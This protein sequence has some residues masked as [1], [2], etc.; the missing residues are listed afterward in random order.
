MLCCLWVTFVVVVVAV[1]MALVVAL[2]PVYMALE[3]VEVVA[4]GLV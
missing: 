3:L 1:L 2:G 4:L